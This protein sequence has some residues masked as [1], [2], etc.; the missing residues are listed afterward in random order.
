MNV[1]NLT[2]FPPNDH[3]IFTYPSSGDLAVDSENPDTFVKYELIRLPIELGGSSKNATDFVAFSKVCVHLWCSPNYNP[4]QTVNPNENGYVSPTGSPPGTTHEQYECPCHGSI[5][6]IPDGL[7][8]GGPASLQPAPTNAIPMVTLQ[9]D[10]SGNLYVF[11]S[12]YDPASE[13]TP[14]SLPSGVNPIEGDG[15][16]GYGRDYLSYENFIKPRAQLPA[17]PDDLTKA[18]P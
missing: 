4:Q 5:Y 8:V 7:A 18:I 12:N 15:T 3:W 9:A 6:R 2:T 10:S 17:N 14:T 1:N 16:L 11:A 13:K